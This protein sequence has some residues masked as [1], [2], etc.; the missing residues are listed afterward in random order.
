M[1]FYPMSMHLHSIHQPGASMEGHMYNAKTLGMQYIRY[2]DHDTRTGRKCV[3][4]TSFDFGKGL[5]KYNDFKNEVVAWEIIG[6]P[7][8]ELQEGALTVRA[9]G[10]GK[11]DG[12]YFYSTDK[13]HTTALLSDVKLTFD[14]DYECD[15]DSRIIFDVTLSQRPPEHK[16]AHYRYVIGKI[17]ENL[18]PYYVEVEMPKKENGAYLFN[19]TTDI[20]NDERVGGLDNVFA[21]INIIV[22]KNAVITL[23]RFEIET[24]YGFNDLI[25]RQRALAEKIG[26]KYGI[27]PFVTTEI[28]GA[29]QHKNCFTS[30][31]PVINY[32]ERGY[33]VTEEEAVEH[34]LSHGGIFSYNHPFEA[35][36]YKGQDFTR[37]DIERIIAY[38]I[39]HL[40]EKKVYGA[41]LMEVGFPEGRGYFTLNDYLRLWDALSLRGIFIT[42]DGDSDSHYSDRGW[43]K[44][45]NFASWIGVDD[46]LEFPIAEEEFTLAMKRGN[47]YMGDPVFL[48]GEV[49]FSSE[50]RPMGSVVRTDESF[51]NVFIG[52]K[53]IKAGS[54]VRAIFDG[55]CLFEEKMEADGDY[56]RSYTIGP[57]E[58]VSFTRIEL[59]N[60]DGRCIMLTNPIYYVKGL[61]RGFVPVERAAYFGSK[62]HAFDEERMTCDFKEEIDLPDW[63][64]S[65]EGKILLHIGDTESYR[66]PFYK[67]LFELVK[68]DVILH[69]GDMADEV[70]AGRMSEVR[71]E[72]LY[73]IAS[74]CDM[75]KDSGAEIYIVPGN[76]DIREEINKLLPEAKVLKNNDII[77]VDGVECRVGHEVKSITYNKKWAFYGH[78]YT[79][80]TWKYEDNDP[81]KECRFNSCTGAFI[82]SVA[83]GK[84]HKVALPKIK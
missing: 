4:V 81:E 59:Y 64:N 53:D 28:S 6:N 74:L 5:M 63:L 79:G 10:E 51:S 55:E 38:E 39:E 33:S 50:D 7:I 32:E 72:Y 43:F 29:G 24:K 40:S 46:K 54:T 56:E 42:G 82:I 65:T 80:E 37:E 34:I 12:I 70:K 60:P 52:I 22:E 45:N 19:L 3:P 35:T 41:T 11:G 77:T 71:E 73:K 20:G 23:K 75:M 9:S 21:T 84:Y 36:K 31:V 44:G 57:S 17:A 26:E 67:K 47:V 66:Y 76:N 13:R 15:E 30:S 27:K 61:Y 14:F 69:T 68:P 8:C 58:N 78:G 83:E 18:P 2:T 62:R 49:E 48:K 25:L 1:K 16:E